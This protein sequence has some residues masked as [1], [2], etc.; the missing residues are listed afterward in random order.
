MKKI[1]IVDD[2]PIFL[3]TL[4]NT[5]CSFNYS[6]DTVNNAKDALKKLHL[7]TYDI[8]ISDICMPQ[9]DGL[10]LLDRIRKTISTEIPVI[11]MTGFISAEYA[12]KAVQLGASDFI[13]KPT[14]TNVIIRSIKTQLEKA[15]RKIIP[16]TMPDYISDL[17]F[18]FKFT[19]E[20]FTKRNMAKRVVDFIGNLC[21]IPSSAFNAIELC[22]DE[23]LH[24]SFIHGILEL[25][26]EERSLP[27]DAYWALIADLIQKENIKTQY[28]LLNLKIS[29]LNGIF[30][31]SITDTGNGFNYR[32][33]IIPNRDSISFEETG[34]GIS[35]IQILTDKMEYS[36]GGRTI[37]F[38]KKIGD[39]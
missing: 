16:S 30:K 27:H 36:N 5:L 2:S 25:K 12:I 26:N 14:D 20:H 38:E 33:Y 6:V 24:N 13:G 18:N 37:T 7:K 32:Q 35:F 28:I 9:I 21:N 29:P 3:E 22:L 39:Q 15:K 31:A 1:L 8:I 11:L 19:P 10:E 17:S 4:E 34:R 23:I